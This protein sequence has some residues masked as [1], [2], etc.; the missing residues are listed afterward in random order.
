MAT[1]FD[2]IAFV[3]HSLLSVLWWAIIVMVVMSWLYS[4][5]I[6]N[7]TNQFAAQLSNALQVMTEPILAP[8]RRFMP[9]MGGLDLSPLIVLILIQGVQIYFVPLIAA[10]G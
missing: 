10:I 7:P 3:V 8:I 4:F 6:L 9:D 2:F 1:I 5:G